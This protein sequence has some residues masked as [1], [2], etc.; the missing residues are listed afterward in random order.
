MLLM[1]KTKMTYLPNL[2]PPAQACCIC[3]SNTGFVQCTCHCT[4]QQQESR[5]PSAG[6]EPLPKR[7]G[8]ALACTPCCIEWEQICGGG[9]FRRGTVD[10]RAG[11]RLGVIRLAHAHTTGLAC[12]AGPSVHCIIRVGRQEH[13][14][15]GWGRAPPGQDVNTGCLE[16]DDAMP[17]DAWRTASYGGCCSLI[18]SAMP[19]PAA[20]PGPSPGVLATVDT[21]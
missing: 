20:R 19:T 15:G 18:R 12:H 10:K 11:V 9:V 3:G 14:N 21:K 6:T 8:D 5:A 17:G 7:L 2:A 1:R 13:A 4:R 16:S